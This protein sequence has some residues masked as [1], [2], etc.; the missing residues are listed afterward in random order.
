[1]EITKEMCYDGRSG[2]KKSG[3]E[4][5]WTQWEL[6]ELWKCREDPVY[7][8]CNYV[9]IIDLDKG[10]VNFNL[11]EYQKEMLQ[12]MV[13]NRFS[14]MCTA[15]Q[16][17]KTT[18]VAAYLLWAALFNDSY[19]IAILANKADQSREIMA[20][21]Q[22]MYENL[23]FWLQPGVRTWNKG[24]ILLG[25]GTVIFCAATSG[26][27]IRGRSVNL[28]YLD[29]FAFVQN[30][31]EFY[32]STYPVVTAGS[33]TKVIITSTPK[34][35]NLFYKLWSEAESGK[36]AYKHVMVKWDR[37]PRRGEAWR[38]EQLRNM[39]QKQFDQEFECVVGDTVVTVRDTFTGEVKDMKI[40]ELYDLILRCELGGSL[41]NK[42]LERI[43]NGMCLQTE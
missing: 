9:K 35:M 41:N 13:D 17:G 6:E 43:E 22:L 3:V 8:M 7:F 10:L 11:F 5:E 21:L 25:N 33:D 26:S 39:S 27:S 4:W 2:I 19:T 28:V 31:L 15:R 38:L 42:D 16:M 37:H 1:M 34:G 23:P 24:D 36:N 40:S 30:D 29:E 20:R 18:L 14:I 12:C 32:T